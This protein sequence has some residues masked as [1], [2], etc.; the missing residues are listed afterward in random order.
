MFGASHAGIFLKFSMRE[1]CL[2]TPVDDSCAMFVSSQVRTRRQANR[3]QY[4]H[5]L[6]LQALSN[7]EP[8]PSESVVRRFRNSSSACGFMNSGLSQFVLRSLALVNGIGL[9]YQDSYRGTHASFATSG[10]Q[11]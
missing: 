6:R 9:E 10:L 1:L 2:L 4:E 8:R 3:V 11:L 7:V 5:D